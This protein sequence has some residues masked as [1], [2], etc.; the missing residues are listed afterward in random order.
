[1]FDKS[2][3]LCSTMGA[4]VI[5]IYEFGVTKELQR[6]N[7][8]CWEKNNCALITSILTISGSQMKSFLVRRNHFVC[9]FGRRFTK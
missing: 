9:I 7:K 4:I 3:V 8:D 6:K 5:G 2:L 1:M